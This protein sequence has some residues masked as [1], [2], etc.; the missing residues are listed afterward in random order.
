MA[1]LDSVASITNSA[2]V[3]SSFANKIIVKPQDFQGFCGYV[4]DAMDL[5]EWN[6]ESDITD[7]YIEDNTSIQDHIALKPETFTVRGY[8]GELVYGNKTVMVK[9]ADG[10]LKPTMQQE[11]PYLTSINNSL[12]LASAYFPQYTTQAQALYNQAAQT[13]KTALKA[14]QTAE[15]LYNKYYKKQKISPQDNRQTQ[16]YT[17]F[18]QLW[19]YRRIFTIQTFLGTF[20]NMAISSCRPSQVGDQNMITEFSITFKKLRFAKTPVI[21]NVGDKY[22]QQKTTTN[23]LGKNKPKNENTLLLDTKNTYINACKKTYEFV[24]KLFGGA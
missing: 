8:V 5:E 4:F 16:A 19:L 6:L 1:I 17:F 9:Q 20:E 13:Y 7:H 2:D 10:T 3:F 22:S 23:K 11:V 14:K 12:Q 18:Y 24:K 21:S 15:D